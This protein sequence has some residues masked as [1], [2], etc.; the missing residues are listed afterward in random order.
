M[1][2]SLALVL[3]NAVDVPILPAPILPALAHPVP[4]PSLPLPPAV[5]ALPADIYLAMHLLPRLGEEVLVEAGRLR[6]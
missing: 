4:P 5:I 1:P 2:S 6:E 3:P